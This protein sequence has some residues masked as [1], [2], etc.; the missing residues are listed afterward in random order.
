MEESWGQREHLAGYWS[1]LAEGSLES[2]GMVEDQS[3][4]P[5]GSQRMLRW[6]VAGPKQGPVVAE[7]EETQW[8]FVLV[9]RLVVVLWHQTSFVVGW[10]KALQ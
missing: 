10:R 6:A 3:H 1:I 5:L 8:L 2:S 7:K 4:C 9:R